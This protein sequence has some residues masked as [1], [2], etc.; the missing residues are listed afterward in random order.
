MKQSSVITIFIFFLLL[1]VNDYTG[2]SQYTYKE[3]LELDKKNRITEIYT[4]SIL[5]SIEK[6]DVLFAKNAHGFSFFFYKVQKKYDLAIKYGKIEVKTL[7]SLNIINE[8]HT[9]AYYNL[10]KFHTV[11]DMHFEA[12]KYYKKA[13]KSNKDILKVAQSYCQLGECYFRMGDYYKSLD[14]YLKGIPLIEKHGTKKSTIIH[15]LYFSFNCNQMNTYRS[16]KLGIEF[17]KK[18]DSIIKNTPNH[19]IRTPVICSLY[20]SLANLYSLKYFYDFKKAIFFYSKAIKAALKQQDSAAIANNLLN[21]GEL[22]LNKGNDSSIHFF[23]KSI[24]HDIKKFDVNETYR[25]IA[26]YF[27][28]KNENV[29]ALVNIQKSI[30][31]NFKVTNNNKIIELPISKIL[32]IQY[33]KSSIRALRAKSEILLKLYLKTKKKTYLHEVLKNV[34]ISNRFVSI[35][36]QYNSEISSKF[37]W[38][39]EVSENFSLGIYAAYLLDET[40]SIF[41]FMEANKA[42]LLSQDIEAKKQFLNLPSELVYEN[43]THKK[44]ILKLEEQKGSLNKFPL[45][46]SLFTL[47]EKH[48]NFRDSIN[49]I[50]PEYLSLDQNI[51]PVTLEMVKNDL[52][53][54]D[55]VISF[56]VNN[57][58]IGDEKSSLIGLVITKDKIIPFKT[59][60]SEKTIEGLNTYRKLLSTPLKTKEELNQFKS[61]AYFL[62]NQLFPTQEIKELIKDKNVLIVPDVSM[63]NTPLE[64]LISKKGSFRYLI[65]D[66]NISYAYSLTFSELNKDIIRKTNN[67][68]SLYSPIKF[69]KTNTSSLPFTEKESNDI[70]NIISGNFH[71]FDNA[72]KSNFLKNSANSKIIHLAT[73]ADASGNPQIQFYDSILPLHELY[74][75]KN[76]ADLVV[77]SACETNLGEIKKGEGVL[78]L[79]RGFFHS[80]ANS[81]VSSLWRINDASTSEIMTDFYK[82]LKDNQS[83]TLALNNA[84]RSYLRNHSLS[85]KSPY[86]WASF[87]LIGDTNPVFESNFVLYTSIILIFIVLVFLFLGKRIT[88][89]IKHDTK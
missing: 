3:L 35:V 76:N 1:L 86:Y 19:N 74:T 75:Y 25:N 40:F 16:A 18:G 20:G 51:K 59:P 42:F 38:R 29:R 47:K 15:Y 88:K 68:I 80:G 10:G 84:K 73:H 33:K 13:I 87:I 24:V 64:A 22:Y 17:L 85:E 11:K 34:R 49:L 36:N 60:E 37:L 45:R 50:Y 65:E 63:E 89:H 27:Q 14:F 6:K 4:D 39:E 67:N 78:S 57:I 21:L 44:N 32:N 58:K 69:N 77:L 70:E 7:D 72:N 79:A 83:K 9:N 71:Q 31:Y 53:K 23:N 48:Q 54:S 12:V 43:N 81:V 41:E 2:Y 30:N 55:V 26:Q 66:C 82:N 56:S 62:Y 61:T 46:D 8:D 52:D 28:I 5:S